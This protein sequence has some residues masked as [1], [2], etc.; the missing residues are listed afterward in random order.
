MTETYA[1]LNG[2][3]LDIQTISDS[4]DKALS[5]RHI[6][7]SD[8]TLLQDMGLKA[9][10][11]RL[12][13]Y[14]WAETYDTHRQLLQ[15]LWDKQNFELRHP[16]YGLLR[17]KVDNIHVRHDDMDQVAEIDIDFIEG[18]SSVA[19]AA[20]TDIA[21]QADDMA[22]SGYLEAQDSYRDAMVADGVVD[23]ETIDT[24]LDP[25]LGILD[26]ITAVNAEARSYLKKLDRMDKDLA[27]FCDDITAPVDSLV[28]T[29]ELATSLPGRMIGRVAATVEKL[30]VRF[31]TLKNAPRRF[32]DSI[33]NQLARFTYPA[34]SSLFGSA[35]TDSDTTALADRAAADAYLATCS[36]GLSHAVAQIYAD[37]E[38]VRAAQAQAEYVQV[39]D[40]QGRLTQTPAVA[41]SLNVNQIEESL[42]RVRGVAALAVEA[43]R[44]VDAVRLLSDALL[45][46]VVRVKLDAEK[47][48]TIDVDNAM[49]LH[50]ICLKYGLPY[51]AAERILRINRIKHPN[52][53]SG[54]IDIYES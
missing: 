19:V 29:V 48:V 25:E 17:G 10:R 21:G 2:I 41:A 46:H 50:L 53:V 39:F 8:R 18:I 52:F 6:P 7:F 43:A 22:A 47:I 11:I 34:D 14:F 15:L 20:A 49:P 27:G 13:C 16:Q 33:V 31:I 24:A 3:N 12:R 37:D 23:A 28:D 26:Q 5:E 9:R 4:F 30:T 1:T 44:G 38:Q 54:G 32:L 45:D 40:G 35:S 42:D 36:I 51:R